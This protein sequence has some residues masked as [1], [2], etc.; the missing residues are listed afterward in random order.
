MDIFDIS[1]GKIDGSI[2]G[3]VVSREVQERTPT[4]DTKDDLFSGYKG[5]IVVLKKSGVVALL[6]ENIAIPTSIANLKA[7]GRLIYIASFA[8]SED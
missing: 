6:L 5:E 7:D 1:T 3:G 4:L 8:G 2:I